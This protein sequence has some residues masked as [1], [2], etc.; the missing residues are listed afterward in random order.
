MIDAENSQLGEPSWA[1]VK[2]NGYILWGLSILNYVLGEDNKDKYNRPVRG[3]FGFISDA[4]IS[5]LPYSISYFKE[6]Y[7]TYVMPIWDSPFQ[8]EEITSQLPPI[9]GDDSIVKSS[10]LNNEINGSMDKCRL[11]PSDSDSKALIEAAFASFE[12]CS[13]ATNVHNKSRCTEFGKDKLSF[14]NVV[15]ASDS[16]IRN[17]Q[18]IKVYV[19]KKPVIIKDAPLNDDPEPLVTPTCTICGKPTV[20]D[21]TLCSECK[22]KEQNKRH[23]KYGLYGFITVVCLFLILKGPSIWEVILSPKDATETI[24]YDDDSESHERGQGYKT[25]SFLKTRKSE[26]HIQDADIDQ[27]F[28]IKYQSSSTIKKIQPSEEW[29]HIITPAHQYSQSGNIE[30]VCEP[31]VQGSREG[32]I[33]LVNEDGEK[34]IIKIH[35]TISSQS[36]RGSNV[37]GKETSGITPPTAVQKVVLDDRNSTPP[38]SN[39]EESENTELGTSAEDT[40]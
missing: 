17:Q 16:G 22:E 13:I 27:V 6:I 39:M 4:Q 25:P 28:E 34:C 10:R 5:R 19:K 3:F 40:Y 24:T 14:M 23:F 30:F 20:T 32:L 21:D 38:P 1:L 37:I 7:D 2:K 29:I 26:F 12:D 31:L 8:L 9:S 33:K 36:R 11:F 15:G 18:D 35:Q